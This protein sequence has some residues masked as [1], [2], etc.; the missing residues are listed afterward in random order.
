MRKKYPQ[1]KF[2]CLM[3]TA[4]EHRQDQRC[5][6]AILTV[7]YGRDQYVRQKPGILSRRQPEN[8]SEFI[9]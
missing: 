6:G 8:D 4:R 1:G 3:I 7:L 2:C 5:S 9:V